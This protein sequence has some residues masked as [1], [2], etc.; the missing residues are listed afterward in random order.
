MSCKMHFA[1]G[2]FTFEKRPLFEV[3]SYEMFLSILIS[4]R[5]PTNI[6]LLEVVKMN[7]AHL[8][9]ANCHC[10]RFINFEH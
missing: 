4:K 2:I 10:E 9:R 1:C 3:M 6:T 8:T 7:G 5:M